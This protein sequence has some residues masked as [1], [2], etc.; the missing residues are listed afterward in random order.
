[1]AHSAAAGIACPKQIVLAVSA[2]SLSWTTTNDSS[3]AINSAKEYPWCGIGIWC[4]WVPVLPSILV[5]LKKFK[6][7]HFYVIKN[8]IVKYVDR[9]VHEKCMQKNPGK[10]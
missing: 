1:M 7:S 5:L 3:L 10:K 2:A 4:T 9:Y 8:Y 6:I